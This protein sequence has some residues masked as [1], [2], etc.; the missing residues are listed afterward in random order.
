[1]SKRFP[2]QEGLTISWEAAEKAYQT[3]SKYYGR[4]QSLERLAERGGFGKREFVCL[5]LGREVFKRS[6][7]LTTQEI[8]TVLL[9]S[10]AQKR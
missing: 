2:I 10:D 6:K 9:M 8:D 5:Y 4:G 7:Y 3:Y 1:M